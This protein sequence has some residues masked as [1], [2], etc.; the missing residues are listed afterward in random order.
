MLQRRQ[1]FGAF[2]IVAESR[3][4]ESAGS[5]RENSEKI[6]HGPGEYGVLKHGILNMRSRAMSSSGADFS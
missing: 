5:E 3:S 6:F 4:S 1:R 2:E